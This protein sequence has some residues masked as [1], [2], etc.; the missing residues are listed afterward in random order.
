MTDDEYKS[1][2]DE[3]L[4]KMA[5][6]PDAFS[7][8]SFIA[9]QLVPNHSEN[10]RVFQ[11]AKACS[12]PEIA[13][14]KILNAMAAK[15][16]H[17]QK[18]IEAIGCYPTNP[19]EYIKAI[20]ATRGYTARYTGDL[21]D[22]K[23]RAIDYK[24][25]LN[26]MHLT[27]SDIRLKLEPSKDIDRAFDEWLDREVDHRLITL[28]A[29]VWEPRE[30]LDLPTLNQ[31]FDAICTGYFL[32][33][34]IAKAAV[35][36]FIWQVKRKAVGLKIGDP[37]MAVIRGQSGA[38]KSTFW[39]TVIGPMEEFCHESSL[40][41]ITD[42]RN[43]ELFR[44]PIQNVDELTYSQRADVPT[45]KTIISQSLVSRR[46]FN[47]QR[48]VK[49]PVKCVFVGTCDQPLASL[50]R[51][52]AGMRRF[53]EVETRRKDQTQPFWERLRNFDWTG[54]WQSIDA[55]G[56]DPAAHVAERVRDM[57]EGLRTKTHLECWLEQFMPAHVAKGDFQCADNERAFNADALYLS[58]KSWMDEFGGGVK[59]SMRAWALDFAALMQAGTSGWRKEIGRSRRAFYIMTTYTKR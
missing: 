58:F 57:Q 33:P 56:P 28:M 10:K 37:I 17:K 45:L 5:S 7:D 22:Q 19:R 12:V 52:T 13:I 26:D 9:N 46:I 36:K 8:A 1:H 23:G 42:T 44:Y 49:V 59:V 14:K 30:G 2:I 38:G 20:V 55:E 15:E 41:E 48:V 11:Q 18:V 51:D 16:A 6:D 32:D 53:I 39:E 54:L 25:A 29:T 43:I 31:E 21:S 47:T 40:A 27:L 4:S 3:L 35:R 34:E 50:I 24:T